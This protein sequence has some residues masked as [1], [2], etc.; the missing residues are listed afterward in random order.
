M[1]SRLQALVGSYLIVYS[2]TT[3]SAG[4]TFSSPMLACVVLR[5]M[6][7]LLPPLKLLAGRVYWQS[8]R[9]E[10]QIRW[11]RLVT[12]RRKHFSVHL[13]L[14]NSVSVKGASQTGFL[15][16]VS[17]RRCILLHAYAKATYSHIS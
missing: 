1:E 3:R 4:K 13:E 10:K 12:L 14:L 6:P 5:T 11:S 2:S 16:F 9:D 15:E 7:L 8:S 17:S